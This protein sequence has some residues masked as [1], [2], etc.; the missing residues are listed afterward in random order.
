MSITT[1]YTNTVQYGTIST[2]VSVLGHQ[3]AKI[4]KAKLSE[5]SK[6]QKVE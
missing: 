4:W 6:K 1:I 5:M 3:V 2:D